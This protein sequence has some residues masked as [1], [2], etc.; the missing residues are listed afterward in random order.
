MLESSMR[1]PEFG[2]IVYPGFDHEELVM[3]VSIS[4]IV[5]IAGC[6]LARGA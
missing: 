2:A 4:P 3:P 1:P 5:R 6:L